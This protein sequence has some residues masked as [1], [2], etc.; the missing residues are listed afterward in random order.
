MGNS[1]DAKDDGGQQ[2]SFALVPDVCWALVSSF[3]A[4]PDVYNLAL[5][6]KHFHRSNS[7]VTATTVGSKVMTCNIKSMPELNGRSGTVMDA[8][9][10]KEQVSSGRIPVLVAGMRKPIALKPSCVTS[11]LLATTLLRQSLLSSLG[12]VLDQSKSGITLKSV[13]KLPEGALIAGST[14]AQAC[15]GAIWLS[16]DEAS[17]VDVFCSAKAAPMVRSVSVVES[18]KHFICLNNYWYCAGIPGISLVSSRGESNAILQLFQNV[19][20]LSPSL[21]CSN[22]PHQKV[23]G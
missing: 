11:P 13:L 7:A 9:A 15:L 5:S 21:F 3:A 19:Y 14:I 12:R 18:C 23:A 1:S 20:S 6:S 16:H 2:I 22:N 4:P 8:A 17:D 10:E